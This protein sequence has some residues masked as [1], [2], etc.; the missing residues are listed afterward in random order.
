M[1]FVGIHNHTDRDSNLRLK[2]SIIKVKDLITY[3]NELG[4]SGIALTGHDGCQSHIKAINI[5]KELK[6]KG[7]LPSD[8]KTILGVEFYL[9]DREVVDLKKAN[10]E[11]IDFYHLIVL[12]KSLRGH[13]AL[14]KLSSLSWENS[15]HFKGLERIPLYK[16]QFFEIINEYKGELICS[17]ACLGGELGK[18]SLA[19]LTDG[20]IETK[21]KIHSFILSMKEAFNEDFYLE[22]QP[23]FNEEQIKY[24][25]FLL[26]LSKAY[27]IKAVVSTD[28][29]YLKKELKIFHHYFLNSKEGDRETEDFYSSTYLMGEKEITEYLKGYIDLKTIHNL[30][31]N[32]I[33]I[34]NKIEEYDLYKE[35]Q[36]PKAVIEDFELKHL[37]GLFYE[38]YPNIKKYAYSP[39]EID[40]YFLYLIEEGFIKKGQVISSETL[41]RIEE[42]LW[43][44]WEISEAM[45]QQMSGYYVLTKQIVDEM[46]L[47]SYVGV[48]RGSA[49]G[50]YCCY[51]LDITQ[52]NPLPS[53]FNL[54]FFRH[55][56]PSR[57]DWMDIDI[58]TENDKREIIIEHMKN[59]YG[60]DKIINIGTFKS[61]KAKSSVQTACRGLG[62]DTDTI[63]NISK[64]ATHP[65]LTDCIYGNEEEDLKPLKDFISEIKKY[66][67]LEE[68]IMLFEGLV[69]GRSQ[70]ASGVNK[71]DEGILNHTA[72]M[73]TTS[74]GLVTQYDY[75]DCVYTGG[76]KLDFLS[77][78]ALTKI[79]GCMEILIKEKKIIP[80]ETLRETYNKY[81]HPDVL[82][83][84]NPKLFKLLTDGEVLDAFQF[85]TP[86][87]Q[88]ALSKLAP[89]GS[90]WEL[91]AGNSLM[92]LSVD[93]DIQPIDKYV[94]YRDNID[95]AYKEM[96]ED[97]NLTDEEISKLEPLLKENYFVADTQELAMM[98]SMNI[99]GFNVAEANELRKAIAKVKAKDKLKAI[100]EKFYKKGQEEGNSLN[101]LDYVWNSQIKPML[102]YSFSLLHVASYTT[103]LMQ[104]LNLAL[105]YG[106]IFW[107]TA[108]LSE[109]IGDNGGVAEVVGNMKGLI[110]NPNINLS[111]REFRPYEA[112]NKILYGLLSINGIGK[113]VVDVI[114]NN[115]PYRDLEDFYKRLVEGNLITPLQLFTL[116]KSGALDT[117]SSK[118]RRDIMIEL[119]ERIT[120][121]KEKL[122]MSN[123]SKFANNLPSNFTNEKNYYWFRNIYLKKCKKNEDNFIAPIEALE[124]INKNL[125]IDYSLG[126]NELI[127]PIKPFEKAYKKAIIPLQNWLSTKEAMELYRK[128][129]CRENWNLYCGGTYESWEMDTIY[130]YS[131]RHD[132]EN[133]DLSKIYRIVDFKTLPETPIVEG[134]K[135]SKNGKE[136]N[137]YKLDTIAGTVVNKNKNKNLVYLLTEN[138][139]VPLKFYDAQYKKLDK[140]ITRGEGK[141]KIVLD[142]S[143]FERGT[144]LIV[145][146]YRKLD[147]FI[148]KKNNFDSPVVKLIG[149]DINGLKLQYEKIKE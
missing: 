5:T 37:F 40:R 114:V 123:V 107:K 69:V 147:E 7:E 38:K 143:W 138:G 126:D 71:Y 18:L 93:G 135:T 50:S 116:A 32:T 12:S 29:H 31:E 110:A 119:V 27:N 89:V 51:L 64:L 70:H 105:K 26:D 77:I 85:M 17:S 109:K 54:P 103:I 20:N 11:R 111:D 22:L 14:R 96:R 117:L 132:L 41:E 75:D 4:Y 62:L 42:E 118:S 108:V 142:E 57:A 94:K 95:L 49:A 39:Y 1:A 28:S 66:P 44:W 13:E 15:F 79:R 130:F 80:C 84:D 104:E 76:M 92:R 48:A 83:W 81:L 140:K 16:D 43:T 67:N 90:F 146:G 91:V 63:A 149:K 68:A 98:L 99:A 129:L 52:I 65:T 121:Y 113:D 131:N 88:K 60:K 133:Y 73:R 35:V 21:R 134:T 125:D 59:K 78:S 87:G 82:D 137:I 128:A 141:K 145:T 112:E 9:V 124:W 58:D 120:P 25:K 8:F 136:Y 148:P 102:G 55:A 30:F 36:I 6:A 56:H 2:D 101:I 106:S 61:E 53:Q 47:Y 10:N 122:T 3:A 74:G 45:K 139:I 34:A 24:N 97:Y 23:S 144:K 46:W 33:E 86:Q 115:R 19:Y 72:I 100:K 127:I